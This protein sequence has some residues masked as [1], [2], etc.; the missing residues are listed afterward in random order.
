MTVTPAV[1]DRIDQAA[2]AW[3]AVHGRPEAAPLV[4]DKLRLAQRLAE[5]RSRRWFR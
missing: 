2:A 5:Q 4:A 3:S 1:D